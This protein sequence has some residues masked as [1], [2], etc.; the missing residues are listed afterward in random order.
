MLRAV[1]I[2]SNELNDSRHA[3]HGL[4]KFKKNCGPEKAKKQGVQ[5]CVRTALA[6]EPTLNLIPRT[7]DVERVGGVGQTFVVVEIVT[8]SHRHR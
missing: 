4:P 7:R 3:A 1:R 8:P 2:V 6:L 5:I